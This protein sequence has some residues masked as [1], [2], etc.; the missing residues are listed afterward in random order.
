MGILGAASHLGL[1]SANTQLSRVLEGS[2]ERGEAREECRQTAQ[3][4]PP[5]KDNCSRASFSERLIFMLHV[6][7]L[8]QLVHSE[9]F[10]PAPPAPARAQKMD[11]Q[12]A[13]NE[14]VKPNHP[15]GGNQACWGWGAAKGPR[16]GGRAVPGSADSSRAWKPAWPLDPS[17]QPSTHRAC[18]EAPAEPESGVGRVWRAGEGVRSSSGVTL[19][20]RG[21][22]G[23]TRQAGALW[24]GRGRSRASHRFQQASRQPQSQELLSLSS[25]LR[26]P[27]Q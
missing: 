17:V 19:G 1:R 12:Q 6:K 7:R 9:A 18:T 2:A 15:T 16:P 13:A 10:E 3:S 4:H 14:H 11:F 21:Q 22:A 20:V 8:R 5:A 23:A 24:E 26:A 25:P 27:G